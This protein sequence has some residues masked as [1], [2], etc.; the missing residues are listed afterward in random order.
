MNKTKIN[1]LGIDLTQQRPQV[2][3]AE[4]AEIIECKTLA[5]TPPAALLPL[6]PGESVISG[7][8]AHRHRRG[9]GFAWPPECQV[10]IYS[11]YKN[12]TGRIPLVCAWQKLAKR[13][14]KSF[15]GI[16][17][18]TAIGWRPRGEK[19]LS[20]SAE[21]LIAESVNSWKKKFSNSK[22]A[23][24]IPDSLGEAAQQAL[25][26][27]CDAFL[28]PRPVAVALS[29]CRNNVN[30]FNGLGEDSEEGIA[31]GHLLV[32]TMAF[33]QWEV[34]PI[35]IR[36]KIFNKKLW[37]VP[38]R[39]RTAEGGEISRLGVSFSFGLASSVFDNLDDAWHDVFG[40]PK[41][42]NY[43]IEKIVPNKEQIE[44]LRSCVGRGWTEKDRRN[45][46]ILDAWKDMVWTPK[47]NSVDLFK[48][49]LVNL[50]DQQLKCLPDKAKEKCLGIII[51]GACARIHITETRS[52][53]DFVAGAFKPEDVT[54]S[55]GFEAVRGAAHTA[56][57]LENGL[58]CYRET[59]LPIEI[60]HH[61]RDRH[62]DWKNA[63]KLLV[64]GTTVRA[65]EEYKYNEPVTGLKIKQG[66]KTLN[67]V[68]RRSTTKNE[69]VFRKV[70]AE[71]PEETQ[72]DESVLISANLRPGQGFAKVT[73]NSKRRGVFSTLLN[74]RTME[75]CEEPPPPNLS[76]L[77]QVS[78]VIYDSELWTN[79]ENFLKAAINSLENETDDL[80]NNLDFLRNHINRYP[81]ADKHDE[82]RGDIPRDDPFLHY[83]VF[84]SDGDL[85]TV[86]E[87]QLA[88][89]FIDFCDEY[90][91][92]SNNHKKKKKTQQ[93]A[94]W[95][96]LSC[97]Q[98]ILNSSRRNLKLLGRKTRDVDLHTIGLCWDKKNDLTDFFAAL[99]QVFLSG[100][101]SINHW[102]R[103]SRNIVR[104][105][106]HALKPEVVPDQRLANIIDGVY[107]A[108]LKEINN[109]N[110][111]RKFDNCI[112]LLLYLLKR[113]RYVANFLAP[114]SELAIKI[115]EILNNLITNKR[116]QLS[117]RQFTIVSITL[118]FFRKEASFADLQGIMIEE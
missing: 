80:I 118:K 39:N 67:L 69:K 117:N 96:Y 27:N 111:E 59:I 84:P 46:Q 21:R 14:V 47:S 108:L 16:L 72:K 3:I 110:F 114:E 61:R 85:T 103:A 11:N 93:A 44:A 101:E 35:E 38:V 60:Y 65:G 100:R 56:D 41:V 106:D 5:D 79:A 54:I 22:A 88:K 8:S 115:D 37:L 57:A 63:Y 89:Q 52:L 1:C 24:I 112:L 66:E 7:A 13:S 23:I 4:D 30:S 28:T 19:E 49:E 9:T 91:A 95:L 15:S 31:I 116:R 43:S 2:A 51:D 48:E 82:Y 33:D 90:F 73:I 40:S 42:I 25:I 104:F 75:D 36:A 83:G 26:D 102:L 18:D 97:P 32:I 45:L 107:F 71:I 29:W 74:W 92:N 113:R 78:K 12:G 55:D 17:G 94:S 86:M 87:P 81:L 76:Y 99:E 68:L 62:G 70:S 77:P 98:S 50:R 20:C 10:P 105:R 58:P 64:E 34:V 53:G 109:H 6:I